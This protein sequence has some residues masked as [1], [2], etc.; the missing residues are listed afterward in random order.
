MASK[1][2]AP[3]NAG[4]HG[5]ARVSSTASATS[6]LP[7]S[8][9]V[10]FLDAGVNAG[11]AAATVVYTATRPGNQSIGFAAFWTLLGALMFVEGRGELRYGG[12]AVSAANAAYLALRVFQLVKVEPSVSTTPIPGTGTVNYQQA[13]A[14]MAVMLQQTPA[15]APQGAVAAL[16]ARTQNR[17]TGACA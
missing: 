15:P 11:V 7:E 4:R 17:Y 10:R 13:S 14:R 8:G 2:R 16:L 6:I 1:P 5:V 12:G 9:E 3:N